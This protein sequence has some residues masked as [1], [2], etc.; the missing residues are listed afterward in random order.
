VEAGWGEDNHE[1][2]KNESGIF[3]PIGLDMISD[4]TKV[5]CPSGAAL[6]ATNAR[7]AAGGVPVN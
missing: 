6:A 3:L 2:L 4:K 7:S 1:F 5:I